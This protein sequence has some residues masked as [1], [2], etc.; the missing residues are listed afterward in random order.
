M[1][2]ELTA[3]DIAFFPEDP[4][5]N[6]VFEASIPMPPAGHIVSLTHRIEFDTDIFGP[7]STERMLMGRSVEMKL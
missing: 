5:H 7:M 1:R 2:L 6:C 4:F 3:V